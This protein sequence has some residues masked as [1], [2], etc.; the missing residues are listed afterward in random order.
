VVGLTPDDEAFATTV[1]DAVVAGAPASDLRALHAKG[2]LCAA[3]FEATPDAARVSRAAHLDGSPVRAHVRFS[4]GSGVVGAD[5]APR[6]GRGMAVKLY[7]PDGTTTDIVAVTLPAFFVRTPADFLEFVHARR[8]DPGTGE[9]DPARI[10]AF[11]N[12]HP[13]ALAALGAVVSAQPTDSYLSCAYNALHT[14]HFERADGTVT[15]GRYHLEPAAGV[16]T[17]AVEEAERRAVDHLRH[18][19]E[20]RL[21]QAPAVFVLSVSLAHADD[22]LDDPT[23]VWPDERE[24]VVLGHLRISGLASDRE[25]DGDVLVF[26]PTRVTDGIGLSNDPILH[27]RRAAYAASVLRRSGLQLSRDAR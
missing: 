3:T 9:P 25:R 5:Y 6:E 20:A 4:N 18:D 26:D 15:P 27:F 11:V 19:L 14:Y 23:A 12:D 17:I 1:I 10:G 7:L 8:P 24:R 2:T 16:V 22:P 21:A 13:E